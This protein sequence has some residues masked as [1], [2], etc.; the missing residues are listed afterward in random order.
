MSWHNSGLA[1]DEVHALTEHF[2]IDLYQAIT[3]LDKGYNADSLISEYGTL[4]KTWLLA[5]LD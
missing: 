3:L 4:P 2:N 5:L 1:K